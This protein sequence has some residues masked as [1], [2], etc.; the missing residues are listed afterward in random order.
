MLWELLIIFV[1][2]LTS[3]KC[4]QHLLGSREI[5]R[6]CRFVDGFGSWM[7][8]VNIF[9]DEIMADGGEAFVDE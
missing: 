4:M 8:G 9:D 7:E 6:K 5:G 3:V 2:K 1:P